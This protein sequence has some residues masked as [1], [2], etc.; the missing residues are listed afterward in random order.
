[1][2]GA[3]SYMI[4]YAIWLIRAQPLSVWMLLPEVHEHYSMQ[5]KMAEHGYVVY[6]FA[7]PL[8]LL[9]ALYHG[10]TR[11]LK[12]WFSICPRHQT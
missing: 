9:D 12:Y 4:I 7:P 3:L 10:R 8:L 6:D 1:M 5:Q 11:Y 2:P